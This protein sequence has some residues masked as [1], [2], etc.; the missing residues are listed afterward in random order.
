M[1]D[2]SKTLPVSG[3]ASAAVPARSGQV[4]SGTA[5]VAR[6]AYLALP[7]DVAPDFVAAGAK[8]LSALGFGVALG[9]EGSERRTRTAAEQLALVR[10]LGALALPTG[11]VAGAG[12]ESANGAPTLADE[13][14]A[15]VREAQTIE[16]NGGV[17]LILPLTVLSRRRAKESEY[18]EA[19]R[20]VFARLGG[21]LLVDW[22]S[23]K[24]RPELYDYFPGASFERVM[25]LEPTKV[26]GARV[27]LFDVAREAKLRR[28]LA[29]RDQLLFTADR[30]H[31]GPLLFGGNPAAPP[32]AFVPAL[33]NVE[34][35]GRSVALGD[36]SHALLA[37]PG[38]EEALAKA[39]E[40]LTA[41]ELAGWKAAAA[42]LD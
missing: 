36:F 33:K 42:E 14:A 2:P 24:L 30:A 31:L 19:Y 5:P 13:I 41:G 1:P 9:T 11:F 15:V 34:L 23:A 35:A 7:A 37:L 6:L 25:A 26:R 22:T 27:A 29:A 12:D 17:P 21:P 32:G 28:A 20:A 3:Q 40:R 38:R 8:R 16:E 10:T 18:V 4:P 39:L